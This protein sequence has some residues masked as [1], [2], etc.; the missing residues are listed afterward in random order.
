[1]TRGVGVVEELELA[2]ELEG[3]ARGTSQFKQLLR[4]R[5]VDKCREIK[6]FRVCSECPA[7]DHCS[8]LREYLRNDP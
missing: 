8:L 5:K 2:L 3:Y 7:F 4:E 6:R 1:M